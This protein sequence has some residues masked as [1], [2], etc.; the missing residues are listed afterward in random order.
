MR[1]M[2]AVLVKR[3]VG[4]ALQQASNGKNGKLTH[5]LV[6]RRSVQ[7]SYPLSM[8]TLLKVAQD[9]VSCVGGV[10]LVLPSIL[11]VTPGM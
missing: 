11:H 2:V 3:Y 9:I 1:G 6:L 8:V 4:D 10:Q 7:I 5:R